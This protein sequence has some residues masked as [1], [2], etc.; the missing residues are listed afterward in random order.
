MVGKS[1]NLTGRTPNKDITKSPLM[2]GNPKGAAIRKPVT[3]PKNYLDTSS[4][5]KNPE[6]E[7]E[8]SKV[9][10]MSTRQTRTASPIPSSQPIQEQTTQQPDRVSRTK[11]MVRKHMFYSTAQL[12]QTTRIAEELMQR[13]AKARASGTSRQLSSEIITRNTVIRAATDAVLS[14]FETPETDFVDNEE[15]LKQLIQDQMKKNVKQRSK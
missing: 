12:D 9:I 15:E 6:Q 5:A 4:S 7:D 10:E 1:V 2:M 13:K 11:D 14:F 3:T 8:Q